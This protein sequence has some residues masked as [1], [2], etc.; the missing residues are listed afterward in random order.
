M[1][2]FSD[3]IHCQRA[4][5]QLDMLSFRLNVLLGAEDGRQ[6]LAHELNQ[7]D[8]GLRPEIFK[9]AVTRRQLKFV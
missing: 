2:T 8:P 5:K 9:L 7:S 6:T 1:S 3:Q 4:A